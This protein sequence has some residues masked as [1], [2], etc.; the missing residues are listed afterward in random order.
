MGVY[1][2]GDMQGVI[3]RDI[4]RAPNGDSRDDGAVAPVNRKATLLV[5]RIRWHGGSG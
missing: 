3:K 5:R 4:V 2:R 1:L